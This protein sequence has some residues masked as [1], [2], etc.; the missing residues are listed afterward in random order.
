MILILVN[1]ECRY[2]SRYYPEKIDMERW[3]CEWCIHEEEK[4]GRKTKR[5]RRDHHGPPSGL[6][7]TDLATVKK[8]GGGGGSSKAV[9][10]WRKLAKAAKMGSGRRYKLLAD[11]LCS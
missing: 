1:D 7:L 8:G 11:V 2:C 3:G 4:E 5:P 9:D 6:H 10:R